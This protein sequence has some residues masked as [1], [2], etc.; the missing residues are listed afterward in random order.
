MFYMGGLGFLGGSDG[1]ESAGKAGDPG[2]IPGWGKIPCRREWQP[3]PV[4]LL[5]NAMHRG[6][7]WATVHGITNSQTGLSN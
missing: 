6:A 4:F 7:W 3:I 5:E 1:K 2:L